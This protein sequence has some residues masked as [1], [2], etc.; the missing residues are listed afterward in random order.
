MRKVIRVRQ[1]SLESF[2]ALQALG[3][4]VIFVGGR[5]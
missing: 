5:V 2:R 3:Y 4:T 1:L